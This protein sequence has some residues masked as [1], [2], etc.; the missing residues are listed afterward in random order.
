MFSALFGAAEVSAPAGVESIPVWPDGAPG[1]VGT[2]PLDVPT[3][4][5]YPA[6]A[7]KNTGASVIVCPGGGYSGLAMG[8]EGHEVAQWLQ[9]NGVSAYVLQYRLAPR[10]KYPAPQQDAQR[11][12]RIVRSH[13][14]EW[15]IDPNKIGILGFSAGGHLSAMTGVHYIDGKPD[16]EDAV[17]RVS[18]RPDFIVLVY[19]VTTMEGPATHA[20]CVKNLLG[21]SPDPALVKE[22]STQLHVNANTPPTFILHTTMDQAVPVANAILFFEAC[23]KAGVP[24]EMHLFEQG[25]HGVGMGG[26]RAPG[27]SVGEWPGLLLK[28]LQVRGVLPATNCMAI[29]R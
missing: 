22:C 19:A 15:K 4:Y 12:V 7:D 1:A 6:P 20:G 24:V 25:K 29:R 23:V 9:S 5:L 16:S 18:T 11:A 26:V 13:A 8:Y 2:E 17:E 28:W 21:E 27:N 14:A 10:Y 3:L